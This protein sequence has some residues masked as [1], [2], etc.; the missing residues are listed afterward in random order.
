MKGIFVKTNGL[1]YN[2]YY[3]EKM[4][5]RLNE[6][7]IDIVFYELDYN[8]IDNYV[9]FIQDNKPFFVIDINGGALVYGES[10]GNKV[11]LCDILGF[12]HISIFTEDP[13]L[14]YPVLLNAIGSRNFIQIITDMK[15]IDF[16]RSLGYQ[17]IY[18]LAPFI[19][20]ELLQRDIPE[21]KDIK[22]LFPGP[23]VD[24]NIIV[25]ESAK[26][27]PQ[28]IMPIFVETGEFMHRNP[29]VDA[30]FALEYILPLFNYEIQENF[31]KW[32]NENKEQYINFLVNVGLYN[33]ARKR[34]FAISFLEGI[35]IKILGDAQI[36]LKEGQEVITAET[37]EDVL[38]IYANS[39]ISFLSFPSIVPS[40]IG[41]TPL[42]VASQQ[43]CIMIDYRASM[44]SFFIPD[45]EA[46]TYSPLDRLDIEE[47][48]LFLLDNEETTKEIAKN[49]KEKVRSFFTEINRAQFVADIIKQ[50]YEQAMSSLNGQKESD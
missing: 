4:I 36:P 43:S 5:G 16:I 15:H 34:L 21:E 49:S 18:F 2:S 19:A 31:I 8:N 39:L 14:Y 30:I 50:I 3:I 45:Q 13:M 23:I 37:Q 17:N 46:I 24:P 41:F 33:T 28:D 20:E 9:K 7:G 12:I 42:E 47:K 35:D 32:R 38:N 40:G 22:V 11:S 27:F 29:E 10:E 44:P 26:I 25:Q 48:L 6:F 1:S